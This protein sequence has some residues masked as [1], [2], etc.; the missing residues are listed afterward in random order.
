MQ[1]PE[2]NSLIQ[3]IKQNLPKK[4]LEKPIWLAY[5]YKQNRDGTYSKPPCS[6]KGH[7]IEAD[8]S[9]VTFY[10]ACQDGYPGIKITH[11]IP[12]NFFIVFIYPPRLNSLDFNISLLSYEV[13]K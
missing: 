10:E 6:N 7:T 1:I 11:K 5:Y 9:G 8:S 4:L 13:C 12:N 2:K 3:K